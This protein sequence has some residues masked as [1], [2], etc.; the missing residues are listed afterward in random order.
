[1]ASAGG[2]AGRRS[3][4]QHLSVLVAANLFV[5][6]FVGIVGII[7]VARSHRSVQYLTETVAPAAQANAAARQDLTDSETYLWGYGISGDPAQLLQYHQAVDRFEARRAELLE[8]RSID[9]QLALLIDDFAL[10]ADSWF[11]AYAGPRVAG[12]VGPSSFDEAQ[13]DRGRLLFSQVRTANTAVNARL[14]Q[15][16]AEAES[17]AADLSH[18][19]T[20][21]LVA[22]LVIGAGLSSLVGARVGRRVTEPLSGLETTAYR[23]A[24]GEH[25]ARAPESGP[26]EVVQVA[27]AVNR[28][29]D[30]NDRARAVEGRVVEQLRALDA[31]KSDFVSNVSH[32][33]RTPLTS[34]RGY[35][36]LLEDE[37]REHAIDSEVDM[38]SAIKRNVDRLGELINDLL[39]LTQSEVQQRADLKPL[40]LALLTREIITDLRVASSQQ[41]VAIRLGLPGTPVPVHADRG[42]ITRVVA[43]LVSNAVKFSQGATE[44]AVAVLAD[45]DDAV[46]TV[47]DHGIGIP[48][49]ELDQ[50]GSRFYRASNAVAMDITGTGLGLRI[51][52][53]IVE[54]DQGSVDLRSQQGVGTTVWVRL[55]LA[56]NDTA[57]AAPP[58]DSGREE[59]YEEAVETAGPVA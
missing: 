15:M 59:S 56:T 24:M 49:A 57:A 20:E 32:E 43:N 36:E 14:D 45:G 9:G 31:V 25:H 55:P 16:S 40:D 3:V 23:L 53:A 39:A 10:A 21:V 13:F 51:V 50:L 12:A 41:G 48:A 4:S 30:E 35:A 22:V 52:Q 18:N 47:Q 28:L 34:I 1:M 38:I 42:Q 46:L 5:V 33:L 2:A 29:A 7:V 17:A 6:L 58:V 27:A 8:M 44:V 37:I 11:E 19:T 54:N 26:R